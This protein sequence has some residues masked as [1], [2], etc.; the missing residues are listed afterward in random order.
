M[1]PSPRHVLRKPHP[2]HT[3]LHAGRHTGRDPPA[4]LDWRVL[5]PPP[6]DATQDVRCRALVDRLVG[7]RALDHEVLAGARLAHAVLDGTRGPPTTLGAVGD[8]G[9]PGGGG[10]S[11]ACASRF[12]EPRLVAAVCLPARPA[13]ARRW[14]AARG[15]ASSDVHRRESTQHRMPERCTP[16]RRAYSPRVSAHRTPH[17]TH[18]TPHTTHTQH[19]TAHSVQTGDGNRR[20]GG[21]V[22][23]SR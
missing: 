6:T 12:A 23:L 21:A 15:G 11:A 20:V 3:P 22:V 10:R 14:Y 1:R 13:G 19:D 5:A 4:T 9:A 7:A 18:H 16:A 2:V 8:A 17:T